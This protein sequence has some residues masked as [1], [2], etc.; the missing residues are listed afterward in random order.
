MEKKIKIK[1]TS[2]NPLNEALQKLKLNDTIKDFT[3]VI[4]EADG[5]FTSILNT[6]DEFNP[7]D[8][9]SVFETEEVENEEQ[10]ETKEQL[11]NKAKDALKQTLTN[12]K[13]LNNILQKI[14]DLSKETGFNTWEL[15]KEKNTAS[16][17]SKNA[18][19]FKQN[20]NLCLSHNGKIEL[21]RSVPELHKWLKEKGYPLPGNDIVIHE[22]V[23]VKEEEDRNWLDLL[24]SYN[25]KKKADLDKTLDK[26]YDR[27]D[28]DTYNTYN[29]KLTDFLTLQNRVQNTQSRLLDKKKK[30]TG[31]LQALNF[32]EKR[33]IDQLG[34]SIPAERAKLIQDLSNATDSVQKEKIQQSLDR[35]TKNEDEIKTRLNELRTNIKK[36]K[37]SSGN[38]IKTKEIGELDWVNQEVDTIQKELDS[39]KNSDDYKKYYDLRANADKMKELDEIRA[40]LHKH[41]VNQA[42]YDKLYSNTDDN[43]FAG[44]GKPIPKEILQADK[45]KKAV[46]NPNRK[47]LRKDTNVD[48]CCGGA[49]VGTAALGPAVA[50][51]A[52]KKKN[53]EKEDVNL[54]ESFKSLIPNDNK[55]YSSKRE[56]VNKFLTWY[57]RNK[58]SIESGEIK[59]PSDIEEQFDSII[60]PT[61]LNNASDSVSRVWS[62]LIINRL[63]P[64]TQKLS[65][66]K[67]IPEE[68]ALA[69]L[70][71]NPNQQICDLLSAELNSYIPNDEEYNFGKVELVPG[72]SL[73]DYT[74]DN[75]NYQ[76]RKNWQKAYYQAKNDG[77]IDKIEVMIKT[78]NDLKK[79]I[80]KPKINASQ[81]TP[82]ELELIQKYNLGNVKTESII[83]ESAK[84]YPWLN[85]ILGQRLTEDDS[86]ADF[87]TG[88]P[89]SSDMDNSGT[90]T[91]TS[92]T[93]DTTSNSPDVDISSDLGGDISNEN[94]SFGDIDISTG[95]SPDDNIEEAPVP[96]NAPEYKIIDVLI[97]DDNNDIKVK[98]QDIDTKETKIKDLEDID[99]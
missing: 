35:L 68:K 37:D 1:S 55:L 74:K 21:F 91:S 63:T 40:L 39:F 19:I 61:F 44:L 16:L 3:P 20:N 52:T 17:K 54:Q 57:K 73:A 67:K 60:E 27:L 18:M 95:Y 88:S 65:A 85:K 77:K 5:K 29:K 2:L 89:I 78:F 7:N 93:A 92:S 71:D 94:P 76:Q 50:Y 90:A 22:S 84:N 97:N 42:Q 41:D 96:I 43:Q 11:L 99:V 75:P 70:M 32:E 48:E 62:K 45:N 6:K 15:N 81:Y 4:V 46:T 47:F 30:A 38:I 82:E 53:E 28:T 10:K 24:N 98:V 13:E 64:V 58:P 51:T 25:N 79:F 31:D 14:Q 36:S 83:F 86:P 56:V 80:K 66:V 59:L 8:I 26:T 9:S 12:S 23:E 33:L 34:V 69:A 49:C 72:N 87:A